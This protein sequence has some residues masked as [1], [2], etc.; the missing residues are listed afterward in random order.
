LRGISFQNMSILSNGSFRLF[1]SSYSFWEI[2]CHLDEQDN[3]TSIKSQL[4]KFKY[5]NILD[6]PTAITAKY[7][8]SKKSILHSRIEDS[9]LILLILGALNN[10]NSIKEFYSCLVKDSNN[11]FRK[12]EDCADRGRD[13]LRESADQYVEFV[14]KIINAIEANNLKHK[15]NKEKHNLVLSL[16]DGWI[17]KLES[18]CGSKEILEQSLPN[19]VY[20]YFS[21]IL[22]RA[23]Q[24]LE[25]NNL[26]IDPNDYEDS[27]ICQHLSLDSDFNFIT[28][29][30][31]FYKALNQ[32]VEILNNLE[33][34]SFQTRV[35]VNKLSYLNRS[36]VA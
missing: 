17:L 12:V 21:Y 10:S 26:N 3:F 22:N 28:E 6:D 7:S 35:K 20:I 25:S 15:T 5:L 13:I 8:N 14:G 19:D 2:L 23:L 9:E 34:T 11:Q 24:Y 27:R 1:G 4:N 32:T 31:R 29:D 33:D 36:T 30:K 16:V 18:D